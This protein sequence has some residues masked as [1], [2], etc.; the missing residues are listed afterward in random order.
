MHD[1]ME[2]ARL[3]RLVCNPIRRSKLKATGS[4]SVRHQEAKCLDELQLKDLGL[5]GAGTEGRGR[6]VIAG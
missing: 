3:E 5:Q 6:L 1:I 4:F 2:S